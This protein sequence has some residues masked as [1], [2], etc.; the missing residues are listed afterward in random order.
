[1]T[2]DEDEL[3]LVLSINASTGSGTLKGMTG[4]AAA[5]WTINNAPPAIQQ[6][7]ERPELED[8][9]RWQDPRV[10]WGVVLPER[11]GYTQDQ[12][13]KLDDIEEPI[14]KLIAAREASLGCAVPVFWY[15]R[16]ASDR[17]RLLRDYRNQ[18]SVSLTG[19]PTGV[20][21]GSVPGYVLICRSPAEIPWELQ[22][23]LNTRRSCSVGRV[24]LTGGALK[25]Y[26]DALLDDWKDDP[27]DPYRALFWSVDLGPED[28]TRK[29]RD[30]VAT[31]LHRQMTG[32]RD[33]G[34]RAT[35]IDGAHTPALKSNLA[36]KLAADRPQLVVTTSHCRTSPLGD[37]EKLRADLGLL[38]DQNYELVKPSDL[39]QWDP[40]GAI[41]YAHA[42]CSAGANDN[43][44]FADLFQ[45]GSDIALTLESLAKAGAVVAPFPTALLGDKRPIKAFI[46]HVEPTF[47]YTIQDP[48]SGQFTTDPLIRSL[49]VRLFQP[50]AVGYAFQSF[51]ASSSSYRTSYEASLAE[52][53]RGGNTRRAMLYSLLAARDV[54]TTVILGDPTVCPKS[55]AGSA[56][57]DVS[58]GS[59]RS[60][61]RRWHS[62]EDGA[63][64]LRNGVQQEPNAQ[65]ANCESRDLNRSEPSA[66]KLVQSLPRE[67][68]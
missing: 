38:E 46:G 31:P 44:N 47:D 42:C 65:I 66:D 22:Y 9:S 21:P 5:K 2:S 58:V 60:L 33:I 10:G 50:W 51:Y 39:A 14:R 11:D 36:A 16:Q 63:R 20:A 40:Y 23:I 55:I 67:P 35:F 59:F 41:W 43:T 6:F 1:V 45:P 48:R 49:Y 30:S 4:E 25:S 7:L 62:R 53:N 18:K 13:A 56:P 24:H 34:Q 52:F 54:Y 17:F 61:L 8:E 19:S 26:I 3:P 15:R 64:T 28:I 68:R 57:H 29:M 27:P 37:P 32:N 12:M